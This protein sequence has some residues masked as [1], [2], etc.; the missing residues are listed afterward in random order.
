MGKDSRAPSSKMNRSVSILA[1]SLAGLIIP[2]L[3][4][5]GGGSGGGDAEGIRGEAHS[6]GAPS[7]TSTAV[8]NDTPLHIPFELER[9]KVILPVRVGGSRVMRVL[10]DTGMHFDGLLVYNRDLKDSLGIDDFIDV[11]VGGAGS[12]AASNAVM[13]DSV[14]FSIGDTELEGQRIIILTGD[15]FEGFPSDGVSGYSLLGHYA[16]EID[17]DLSLITLHDPDDLVVDDSWGSLPLTFKIPA[18]LL[19]KAGIFCVSAILRQGFGRNHMSA[20]MK[21]LARA[22][23][24]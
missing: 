6:S 23:C 19:R 12:G 20:A 21:G 18:L 17:Y 16:V 8:R 2:A 22:P 4:S 15:R 14:T 11:Q 24:L 5:C 10:L 7:E 13:S 1:L 3:L 9:N